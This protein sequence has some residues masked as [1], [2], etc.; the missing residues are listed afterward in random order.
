M[1]NPEILTEKVLAKT[2][3]LQFNETTFRDRT[4]KTKAW[5]WA[6][7]P[8][9]TNAVVIAAVVSDY[10]I[11]VIEEYRIPLKGYEWGFPAGLIDANETVLD[12]ASRELKEETGLTFI[13]ELRT[14]SPL[15]Y[16]SAGMTDEG[17][18]IVYAEAKGEPSSAFNEASELITVHLMTPLEVK[19]L[20]EDSTKKI[21]AKSYFI[22]EQFAHCGSII[23]TETGN[24]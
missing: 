3:F 22:L 7:R 18:Y 5:Y 4:G 8:S 9:K 17:C 19:R 15:I 10:L 24:P 21:G 16:S 14:H 23:G 20:L 6:E 2:K 12:A 11:A 1:K 13:K